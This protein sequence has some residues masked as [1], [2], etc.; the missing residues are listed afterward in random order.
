M[1]V[2]I[3]ACSG[4]DPPPSAGSASPATPSLGPG[5]IIRLGAGSTVGAVDRDAVRRHVQRE[6]DRFVACYRTALA[7]HPE[8]AATV[9]VEL[10]IKPD[11]RAKDVKVSGVDGELAACFATAFEAVRFSRPFDGLA[12]Q[13]KLPLDLRP[14]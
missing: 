2:L 6:L 5:P 14:R 12:V 8:L 11:G 9:D 1:L 13:V 7:T 3:G 4:N 10:V